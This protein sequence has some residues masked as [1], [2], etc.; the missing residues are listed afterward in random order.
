MKLAAGRLTAGRAE[1]PSGL[2]NESDLSAGTT[3]ALLDHVDRRPLGTSWST[4]LPVGQ[5][6]APLWT[7]HFLPDEAAGREEQPVAASGST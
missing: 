1:A 6:M 2:R 4:S 5:E 3:C 7:S